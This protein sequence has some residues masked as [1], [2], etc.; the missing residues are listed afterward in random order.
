MSTQI[1]RLNDFAK[2]GIN[3]DL[4]PWDLPGSFVTEVSNVRINRGKL[5]PFGGSKAW[6]E[7][8]EGFEPGYNISLNSDLGTVWVIAGLDKVY[9]YDGSTFRDISS[10]K[11]YGSIITADIWQ[12]DLMSNVLILNNQNSTPEYWPIPDTNLKLLPLPWADGKTWDDVNE[13]CAIIRSHKQFLFA[14][15]LYSD[16]TRI[17]DGVRWSSPADINSIPV[18]W[19]PTDTTNV[20]GITNLGGAGGNIVD[21]KSLRD[22]FCVYRERGITVFDYVG[23]QFVWQIR[24]M[25]NDVGLISPD[26]IVEVRG[27]HYFIGDGDIYVNDGNT[28]ESILHDRLKNRFV[29]NYDSDNFKNSYAILNVASNEIWFCVPEAGNEYP[30]V[31]YMYNWRDNSFS[32]RDLPG[33]PFAS[34]GKQGTPPVTWDNITSFWEEAQGGWGQRQLTPLDDTIIAVT[35][36]LTPESSGELLILDLDV[37]SSDN[38]FN[39]IIERTGFALEGLNQV[40]TITRLYPHMNGPG[41]VLIQI[42]SQDTAGSPIRWKRPVRFRP[43]IDRKVD[44]RTTGELH[45]FRFTSENNDA[46]WEVSGVDIE[47]VKAGTR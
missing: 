33:A 38:S 27:R 14:L 20:A 13:A 16:G 37:L 5:S 19:D 35:K 31:A 22:A 29:S 32:I 47:Y 17:P 10:D 7:L 6:A 11:G 36:P 21:G 43:G 2:A 46:Y 25:S 23:G 3:S 42:G 40:T 18:T 8:P 41:S 28:I 15:D 44:I 30:N 34:S 26:S 12:G 1:I 4:M 24:H 45:C 9:A 39:T